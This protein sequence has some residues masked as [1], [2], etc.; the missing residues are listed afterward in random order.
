MYGSVVDKVRKFNTFN[1][2]LPIF[3]A[4]GMGRI[5]A[6]DYGTKR[7][8]LA[9]TDPLQMIASGLATVHA[10]DA[11]RFLKEYTGKEEVECFVIGEP[12]GLDNRP[13][14]ATRLVQTFVKLLQK[15]FPDIP[16]FGID[17]R[18]TSKIATQAI[19]MSGA[20][21]KDRQNKE[22]VDVTSAIILLQS[23]MERKGL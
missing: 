10:N 8:G 5:L 22:L 7:V 19:R 9:V 23:Y 16:V 17:E 4:S 18:F 15:E 6:I 21:K 11:V 1:Q 14:D 3:A 20:K 2:S 13:T 12:R